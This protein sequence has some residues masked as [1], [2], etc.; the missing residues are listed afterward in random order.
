[1]FAAV[2]AWRAKTFRALRHPEYRRYWF[3][4]LLSLVGS[5]MQSTAQ[6]YLV[7]ELTNNNSAALGWVTAAQFTPSLL[8]S[9]F[10]GAIVDRVS[11]RRVLLATQLTL[12]ATALILALT[13][14]LGLVTDR[15]SVV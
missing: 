11:R 13:T 15:K 2:Q 1:M 6:S 10:A 12:L 5:W 9:L 8:L 7:L 3:S 14:Q 4:Q